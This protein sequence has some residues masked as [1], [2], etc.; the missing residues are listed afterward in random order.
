M[1]RSSCSWR[2][3][4]WP[5]PSSWVIITNSSLI[6]WLQK[7]QQHIQDAGELEEHSPTYEKPDLLHS[8][9]RPTHPFQFYTSS[10]HRLRYPNSKIFQVFCGYSMQCWLHINDFTLSSCKI[11]LLLPYQ[12]KTNSGYWWP[13]H[14]SIFSTVLPKPIIFF[15]WLSPRIIYL[16]IWS[17]QKYPYNWR[18]AGYIQLFH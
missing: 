12:H 11:T 6:S 8:Q 9:T 10:G 16:N 1:S 2:Y 4:L 3:Q 14:A 5:T 15:K 13:A 18:M 7:H 17:T